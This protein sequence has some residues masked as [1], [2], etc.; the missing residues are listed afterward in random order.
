MNEFV[1]AFDVSSKLTDDAYHVHFS[2]M[3]NGIATRHSDTVD[4]KFVVD[5][6]NVI[7]GLAH[8]GL[9]ALG[10]QMNRTVTDREASYL[11]AEYLR[12]RLEQADE[13]IMFDVSHDEVLRLAQKLGLS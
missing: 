6:H 2:H 3:W 7:V 1:G 13:R 9:V 4:T 12:E 5:G 8:T 11:A 10:D